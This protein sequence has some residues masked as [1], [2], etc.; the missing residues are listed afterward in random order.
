MGNDTPP[1]GMSLMLWP[2]VLDTTDE[3]QSIFHGDKVGSTDGK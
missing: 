2:V 1:I 3:D